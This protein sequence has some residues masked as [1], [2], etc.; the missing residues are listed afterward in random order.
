MGNIKSS[1]F[2]IIEVSLAITI[3][4]LLLGGLMVGITLSIQRQRFSESIHETQ[5]FIQSQ[6]S[7][8]SAVQNDRPADRWCGVS[9]IPEPVGASSECVIFGRVLTFEPGIVKSYAVVG[10]D[11]SNDK[12]LSLVELFDEAQLYVVGDPSSDK[13]FAIPWGAEASTATEY[14]SA[15]ATGGVGALA[16]LKSPVTNSTGLSGSTG[17]Y[18]VQ[19]S[20]TLPINDIPGHPDWLAQSISGRIRTLE[21]TIGMCISSQDAIIRRGAIGIN[22]IATQDAVIGVFNEKVNNFSRQDLGCTS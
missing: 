1:G 9:G 5:S 7:E 14:K 16:I 11:V 13:Q 12:N 19:D 18:V 20:I 6:F 21:G 17:L 8:V 15:G 4:A 10:N 2:T 3:G 22:P